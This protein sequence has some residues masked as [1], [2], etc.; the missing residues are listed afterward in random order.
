M[1][2]LNLFNQFLSNTVLFIYKHSTFTVVLFLTILIFLLG[3]FKPLEMH[4]TI[5]QLINKDFQSSKDYFE[6]KKDFNIQKSAQVIISKDTNFTE[7]DFCQ[8]RKTSQDLIF[9]NP[10][11]SNYFSPIYLRETVFSKKLEI[12]SLNFPYALNYQ[13]NMTSPVDLT[14]LSTSPW[15]DVLV[16][17]DQKTI[18]HQ[19]ELQKSDLKNFE[20]EIVPNH[21]I[22]IKNI[23]NS[24]LK[25]TQFF[26][27]GDIPYQYFFK[28]GLD[29][30]NLLNLLILFIIIIVFRYIYGTYLSAFIFI[31]TVFISSLILFSLMSL[32]QVPVDIL[33]NCLILLMT[34]SSLG[35][36]IFLSSNELKNKVHWIISFKKIILPSFF[37]SFTTFIGF[38]SL[39]SSDIE[40]IRRLGIWG[41][42]SGIIEWFVVML[43][44]PAFLKVFL[45]NKSWVI[46]NELPRF[47]KIESLLSIFSTKKLSNVLILLILTIPFTITHLNI[48]D[49]PD[50]L[51]SVNNPFRQSLSFVQSKF[52]FVGDVSLIF[53]N[54]EQKQENNLKLEKL[55]LHPLVSKIENPYLSLDYFTKPAPLQYHKL[56]EDNLKN[57]SQF[58]R[59]FSENKMRAI[60]YLKQTDMLTIEKFR[61]A[62][63]QDICADHSCY[64]S[65]SLIA[66]ADFS[67]KVPNTLIESF[68]V[69]IILVFIVILF[70]AFST[71]NLKNILALSLSSIWGV[72]ATLFLIYIF[73]IQM[74]FVTSVVIS[75]LVG[76]TGDNTIQYILSGVNNEIHQ[77]L[78]DRGE[79]SFVNTF[80]MIFCSFIFLLYSFEP[81]KTFGL[82][83]VFGLL[84]ALIGDYWILKGLLKSPSKEIS[85]K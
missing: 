37:T 42:I 68:L 43:I 28:K 19:I 29:Y 61:L 78:K 4:I 57:S 21:F 81:P 83:L 67:Q 45:K 80:T 50:K 48:N 85:N 23:F 64:L 44:L 10:D 79:A 59:F 66:Y 60:I 46:K 18:I 49:R 17:R 25:N 53:N 16:S 69:S 6:F 7:D 34:V 1:N 72:A 14:K 56:I 73:Q 75:I 70:L 77:G 74:N 52:G 35:D 65:G 31:L 2:L 9:K 32:F 27:I 26:Y 41:G 5:D 39:C 71:N 8:I 62:I 3:S 12:P 36:F 51:F 55:L 30:N 22:N 15:N 11:F 63:N 47:T 54:Y 76:M 24:S 58:K 40:V 38:I 82:L 84:A 20:T 13:C 33:N